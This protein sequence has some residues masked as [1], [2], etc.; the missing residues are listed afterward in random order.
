MS[1]I[2]G[3]E[4]STKYSNPAFNIYVRCLNKEPIELIKNNCCTENNICFS[5]TKCIVY[6]VKMYHNNMVTNIF[7]IMDGFW[8]H[9]HIYM[10][11]LNIEHKRYAGKLL[12]RYFFVFL[13]IKIKIVLELSSGEIRNSVCE[14]AV[15]ITSKGKQWLKW[16]LAN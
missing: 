16:R 15:V 3:D 2:I 1:H 12:T 4:M 6:C 13:L 7:K 11:I 8:L 5:L 9:R 10:H 14:I